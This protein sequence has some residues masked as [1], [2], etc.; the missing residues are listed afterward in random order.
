MKRTGPNGLDTG[1]GVVCCAPGAA[2]CT[3]LSDSVFGLK[4]G[5]W[6][7]GF[8]FVGRLFHY[9]RISCVCVILC[10]CD[11]FQFSPDFMLQLFNK[12]SWV[13]I[14]SLM[15]VLLEVSTVRKLSNRHREF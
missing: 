13:R 14:W 11:G 15:R 2:G 10:V 12:A 5:G 6:S 8:A 3:N 9:S 7:P 1:V 4:P